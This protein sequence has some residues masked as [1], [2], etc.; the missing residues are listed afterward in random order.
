MAIVFS[1]GTIF[2]IIMVIL[3]SLFQSNTEND[4]TSWLIDISLYNVIAGYW[5]GYNNA[6][7]FKCVVI[8]VVFYSFNIYYLNILLILL[9]F[10]CIFIKF[11]KKFSITARN[12]L[13]CCNLCRNSSFAQISGSMYN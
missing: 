8:I 2:S 3:F 4:F 1:I 11:F 10:I 13:C 12:H 6:T 9:F 5:N 7:L